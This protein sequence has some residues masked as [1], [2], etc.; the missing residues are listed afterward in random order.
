MTQDFNLENHTEHTPM[1]S[2][3]LLLVILGLSDRQLVYEEQ[4]IIKSIISHHFPNHSKQRYEELLQRY[5][6]EV[7]KIDLNHQMLFMK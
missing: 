2:L 7:K 3:I 6:E 5:I 4:I 1:E